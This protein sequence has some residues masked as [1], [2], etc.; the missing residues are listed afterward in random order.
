MDLLRCGFP[1][2]VDFRLGFSNR[3]SWEFLRVSTKTTLRGIHLRGQLV[4][5]KRRLVFFV[6]NEFYALG[7]LFFLRWWWREDSGKMG[8]NLFRVDRGVPATISPWRFV[9]SWWTKNWRWA[10]VP[11]FLL[12]QKWQ[13]KR[14]KWWSDM[15]FVNYLN[16]SILCFQLLVK[17]IGTV[18]TTSEVYFHCTKANGRGMGRCTWC[19]PGN[20]KTDGE[21]SEGQAIERPS[22]H[23][24]GLEATKRSAGFFWVVWKVRNIQILP[25]TVK[26]II[27]SNR[28]KLGLKMIFSTKPTESTN[29][30]YEI[31]FGSTPAPS[32]SYQ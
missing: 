11:C 24:E 21:W 2:L 18:I 8:I 25:S 20:L 12:V 27:V 3:I 7:C 19:I 17:G 30:W 15:R 9:K 29:S 10:A 4:V 22:I 1:N 26:L 16:L 31:W 14:W 6:S 5:D 13:V 23:I 28:E 32:K